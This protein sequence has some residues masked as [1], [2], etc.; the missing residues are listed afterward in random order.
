MRSQRNFLIASFVFAAQACTANNAA[1]I[2]EDGVIKDNGESSMERIN[3][4]VYSD[5]NVR[6]SA[7]SNGCTQ[8]SDF[9]IEHDPDNGKCELLVVRVKPDYCRKASSIVDIQVSWTLPENCEGRDVVF[10][11]KELGELKSNFNRRLIE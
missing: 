4:P 10:I 8:S 7:I 11:N 5:G 9:A 2:P 6:F 1:P 3:D